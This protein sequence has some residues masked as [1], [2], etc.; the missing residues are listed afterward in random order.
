MPCL[1]VSLVLFSVN[2]CKVFNMNGM[3]SHD[4]NCVLLSVWYILNINTVQTN[5]QTNKRKFLHFDKELN[6]GN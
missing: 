2:C 3:S 4:E 5:K 1:G 6:I